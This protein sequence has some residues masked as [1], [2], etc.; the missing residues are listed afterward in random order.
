MQEEDHYQNGMKFPYLKKRLRITGKREIILSPIET[1]IELIENRCSAFLGELDSPSAPNPKILQ[2]ILQGSVLAQVNAGPIRICEVFL[3]DREHY[4][5][6]MI[7]QLIEV[8]AKFVGVCGR[9]VFVNGKI[10]K[11]DQEEFQFKLEQGYH[12]LKRQIESKFGVRVESQGPPSRVGSMRI[13]AARRESSIR[14]DNVFLTDKSRRLQRESSEGAAL[15][16]ELRKER[17]EHSGHFEERHE[18]EEDTEEEA[19]LSRVKPGY[20]ES[21]TA[22]FMRERG[23]S[24]GS[25]S[26][27]GAKER[28]HS[29]YRKQLSV[30][31][32]TEDSDHSRSGSMAES[33]EDLQQRRSSKVVSIA[34]KFEQK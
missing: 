16:E 5:P 34:S 27:E 10:I 3:G 2:N 26:V 11:K 23:T 33:Q 18:E 21:P 32:H 30:R 14:K 15:E 8:V 1:A 17:E 22:E 29:R 19:T 12:D 7:S 9:A 28:A 31:T 25:L 13:M 20:A 4:P 24:S 6:E